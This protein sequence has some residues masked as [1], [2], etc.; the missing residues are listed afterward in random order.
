MH[1]LTPL[2]LMLTT[3]IFPDEPKP[4]KAFLENQS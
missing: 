4:I 3:D 1:Q 2:V